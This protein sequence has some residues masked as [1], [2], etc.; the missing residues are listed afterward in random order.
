MALSVWAAASRS[1][2]R[3]AAGIEQ[4]D[5]IATDAH[6][7]L[8]V[9]YDSGLVFTAHPESHQ[10]SLLMPA[11][12]I[13][14]SPGEREPRAF[15]PDES[16]RARGV[17]VYAALRAL[18]RDGVA[19]IVDRCCALAIRM[20][21]RLAG[22]H[23]VRILNDVV[24][25]QVLVQFRTPGSDDDEAAALTQRVIAGVQKDGTC[26]AGGTR[27]HGQAAMRISI[28]N[29]STNADDIDRS[30][31]AILTACADPT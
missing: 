26:W 9:P 14:M 13:Q 23:S 29:W 16:R 4:A 8:N 1:R 11:H 12:Y 31:E 3:L 27:W 6:K 30:A 5:S 22:H 7:W 21:E 17:P 19:E 25:N 2:R 18:G 24:L 15:T 20:A 10:Q 28:C